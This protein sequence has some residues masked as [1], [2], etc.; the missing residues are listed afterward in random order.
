MHTLQ[1]S[2]PPQAIHSAGAVD[3]R[4]PLRMLA[5][6]AF[7]RAAGAPL[8][9][10]NEAR[11]LKDAKEN[12]SEWLHAIK[13]AHKRIHFESYIIHGDEVGEMFAEALAAKAREGVHVRLIYD[14]MGAL[15]THS[16][17]FWKFL[18]RNGVEVRCFNRLHLDSP[19]G[20]LSRD[21]R[22]VLSIDGR[23]SFVT[24]LCIGRDWAGDPKRHIEP[25]RDTGVMIQGPAVAEIERAFSEMWSLLGLPVPDDE[26]VSEEEIPIAGNCRLRVVASS[27]Y[28]AGLYRLDQLIAAIARRSIW[29]TDAYFL[30]TAPYIQALSAAAA[31]GVD[32]RL[33]LPRGGDIPI[34]RSLSRVGYRPL[35]ESGVRIFEWNGP[36]LHAKTAVVDTRWARVG[37]SNL[38]M[39]S[40]LGNYELD[41][42]VEDQK[43]SEKMEQMYLEDLSNAT[44]VVLTSEHQ[45][46]LPGRERRRGL[47]RRRGS[48]GRAVTG[49][50]RLSNTVGAAMTSRRP[51]GPAEVFVLVTSAALLLCVVFLSAIWP[52]LMSWPFAIFG[53]WMAVSLLIKAVRLHRK[54]QAS[55]GVAH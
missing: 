7:S 32:V 18:R 50:L 10:G 23:V 15:G 42:V 35:L 6:Q 17:R 24:G 13:G 21:H 53:F 11:I 36:M 3:T 44:E 14:W 40:W 28:T 5:D 8:I 37:S 39:A 1:N 25:W 16:R 26:R 19:L 47:R 22:K 49:L 31:D 54:H 46:R 20:W 52:R 34:V 29:L 43:F 51:L 30:A 9:A 4:L 33:L 38:N 45:V 48:A 12:Y 27:P 41:V 55:S 2:G